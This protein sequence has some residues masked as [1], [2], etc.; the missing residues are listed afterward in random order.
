MKNAKTGITENIKKGMTELLI[1]TIL[2]Q[3]DTNIYDI[4]KKL[5]SFSDGACSISYPYA[6]IYRLLDRSYIVECGKQVNENRRRQYYHMTKSG[7][8]YLT[9]MKSE[10]EH[11]MRGVSKLME[12]LAASSQEPAPSAYNS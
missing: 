8:V 12:N 4:L 5:D 3:G 6:A 9:E 11:F 1:L 7:K 2:E 10:Y